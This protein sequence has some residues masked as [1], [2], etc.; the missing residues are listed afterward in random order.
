MKHFIKPVL[1]A[2][3]LAFSANALADWGDRDD[4]RQGFS[5]GANYGGFKS[6]GGDFD[7]ENDFFQVN[8]G[9]RFTP[10]IGVE[11]DYSH[12]GEYGGDLASAELDGWGASVIGY[13]PITQT[14]D[15]YA[16]VGAFKSNVEIDVA[17]FND[18]FDD[19][20]IFY[21]LGAEFYLTRSFSLIAEY[22]RYKVEVDDSDFPVEV[23]SSDTDIDTVKLG[24]KLYL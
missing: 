3:P 23:D 10:F 4:S 1:L 18:N 13:L 12:F 8:G 21:G 22:N 24:A 14:V 2:A 7:D 16:K 15:L 19:E 20:Q 9:Y 5:V 6:R 17:E 11:V